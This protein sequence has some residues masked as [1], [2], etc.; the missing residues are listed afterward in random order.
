MAVVVTTA[1]VLA[2]GGDPVQVFSALASGSFGS[3][4]RILNSL[5]FWVPLLLCATGLL[6]TFTGGLWNIGVEGQMI[7]GAIGATWVSLTFAQPNPEFPNWIILIGEMLAAMVLG[8][9]W[10]S[11]NAV[12]K[13]R[14]GI[15]EIFGGVALNSLA[16][17][18]LNYMIS[19]P[20]VPPRGGTFTSTVPFTPNALLPMYE[21]SRFS[22]LS[23]VIALAALAA[24][25]FML[26]RTFWGLRLKALGKNLRSAFVMGISSEREAILGM[27]VCGALA[28]LAGMVRTTSWFDSLRQGISGGVG[29]LAVLIVL[30]AGTRPVWTAIIAMLFSGLLSG[31][32]I[33]Q[34][35]TQLHSDLSGII[36]GLLVLFVLLFGDFNRVF[37][38]PPVEASPANP[39]AEVEP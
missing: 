10:A 3:P 8:S 23:L 20:W 21:T 12:L 5:A 32:T 17:I 39:V 37:R 27:M 22:P 4:D 9:L 33:V 38:K 31:G 29:F 34:L 35:R 11:L 2:A 18:F 14:G 36:Q 16:S 28:G 19:G 1:L 15:H 26:R 25:A 6:I 7:M 24:V 13:T 30:L